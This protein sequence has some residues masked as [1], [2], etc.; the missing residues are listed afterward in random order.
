MWPH[1]HAAFVSSRGAL[2][3][4]FIKGTMSAEEYAKTLTQ[5]GRHYA[6]FNIF[7]YD[8]ESLFYYTNAEGAEGAALALGPGIYAVSNAVL[9]SPWHK[10]THGKTIFTDCLDKHGVSNAAS[11]K[12]TVKDGRPV[13]K[14]EAA[15]P[16]S[17]R[18]ANELIEALL[19]DPTP[20][21]LET[22]TKHQQTGFPQFWERYLSSIFVRPR[23]VP[24]IGTY[25][26]RSRTVLIEES[27]G[28]WEW[29]EYTLDTKMFLAGRQL[30]N[31]PSSLTNSESSN[32]SNSSRSRS[33]VEHIGLAQEPAPAPLSM[34]GWWAALITG[35]YPAQYWVKTR[36]RLQPAEDTWKVSKVLVV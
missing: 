34:W 14:K 19:F 27:G 24:G 16:L 12:G 11:L 35:A 6:G 21:D 25:G 22:L 7:I 18:I 9:D 26:T 3:S 31:T 30:P 36:Y 33:S 2:V 10:I 28:H 23:W 5:T 4:D 32:S 20:S 17:R 1:G 8:G 29:L 15:L 13:S